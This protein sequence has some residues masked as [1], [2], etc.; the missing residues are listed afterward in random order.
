MNENSE[1]KGVMNKFCKLRK[2]H[3]MLMEEE[4]TTFKEEEGVQ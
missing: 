2:V 4:E 3:V 1:E